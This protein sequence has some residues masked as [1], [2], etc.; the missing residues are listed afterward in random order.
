MINSDEILWGS[1]TTNENGINYII[2]SYGGEAGNGTAYIPVAVGAYNGTVNS[3]KNTFF[4]IKANVPGAGIYLDG[5]YI[6]REAPSKINIQ[7]SSKVGCGKDRN[8]TRR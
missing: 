8:T 7:L 2:P 3:D 1:S 6:N 4:F 5:E